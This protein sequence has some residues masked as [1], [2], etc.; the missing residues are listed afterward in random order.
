MSTPQEDFWKNKI[1]EI[2]AQDN[3]VFDAQLGLIAWE[4]I[5]SKID[6]S[7]ISSY[8][9]CGS[10]IG[11]NIASLKRV[12]PR[13][14]ANIIELAREPYDKCVKDFQIDESFLGSIKDSNFGVKFDLVFTN[15]VLIH[16]NPDDLLETMSRMYEMSSRYIL[17]GEYFNRTPIM[18]TYR[19]EDDRLFKRDF[20]KFFVENFECKVMDYGFLWGHEFDTAGFDDITYWLFEK[21]IE[22][23]N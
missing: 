1:T 12:L 21:Q 3:S 14:S 7:E 10:N 6:K 18:I 23:K 22:P 8:L 11:R 15:G 4:R 5:L 9:D 20:G 2:Y 17:I 19:G 13:A 16:T